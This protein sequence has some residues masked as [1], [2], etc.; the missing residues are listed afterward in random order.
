M[1][2]QWHHSLQRAM[3]FARLVNKGYTFF[4]DV[5]I[6][7]WD[8]GREQGLVFCVYRNGLVQQVGSVFVAEAR[9]SDETIVVTDRTPNAWDHK[10]SEDGWAFGRKYFPGR[11]VDETVQYI[12]QQ[13]CSLLEGK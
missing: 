7:A 5:T 9:S 4:G 1:K 13:I 2:A 10:P 11:A 3:K 6:R 12:R 8:G